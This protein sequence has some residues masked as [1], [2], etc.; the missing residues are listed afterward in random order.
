MALCC[1]TVVRWGVPVVLSRSILLGTLDT[2]S[3]WVVAEAEPATDPESR[4][5]SAA[6]CAAHAPV[7]AKQSINTSKEPNNNSALRIVVSSFAGG[8]DVLC[9]THH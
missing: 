7:G 2:L 4:P 6:A 5:A 8:M 9:A 3:L 1:L